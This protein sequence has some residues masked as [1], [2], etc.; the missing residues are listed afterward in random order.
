MS[1][2]VAGAFALGGVVVGGLLNGFVTRQLEKRAR[3][4]ARRR[5]VDPRRAGDRHGVHAHEPRFERLRPGGRERALAA[6]G[7]VLGNLIGG[8]SDGPVS[9]NVTRALQS[10]RGAGGGR[11]AS[12][13]RRLKLMTPDGYRER[14]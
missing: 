2:W 4:R 7:N 1:A 8:D 9:R 11:R 10:G 5:S 3:R 13:S 6:C 12:L 14:L